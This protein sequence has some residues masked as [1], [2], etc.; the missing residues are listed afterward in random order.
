[1]SENNNELRS[2]KNMDLQKTHIMDTVLRDSHQSLIATRLKTEDMLEV[3]DI[4]DRI[5]YW[6]LEVW[7]GA[8]FDACLRFLREDPWERLKDSSEKRCR[9]PGFRCCFADRTLSAISTTQT[10][11]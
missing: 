5:G 1:M 8:T 7:G 11:W 4:L 2:L 3:T 9:T 6:S 10:T